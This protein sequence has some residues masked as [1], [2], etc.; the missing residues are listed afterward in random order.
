MGHFSMV[1]VLAP[2]NG[3]PRVLRKRLFKAGWS[4]SDLPEIPAL[5][6]ALSCVTH[7]SLSYALRF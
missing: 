2:S 1:T 5:S 3:Q 6:G 7:R 4:H